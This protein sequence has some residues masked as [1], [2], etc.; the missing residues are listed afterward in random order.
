MVRI[1]RGDSDMLYNKKSRVV[2]ILL[3]IVIL[4]SFFTTIISAQSKN[5]SN[6]SEDNIESIALNLNNSFSEEERHPFVINRAASFETDSILVTISHDS[7]YDEFTVDYFS[8]YIQPDI[9]V[10]KIALVNP[11]QKEKESYH[12]I[13][14]FFI[15][16]SNENKAIR[17]AES[18]S[19]HPNI[20]CTSLN[21]YFEA[22]TENPNIPIDPNYTSDTKPFELI[23]AQDAWKTINEVNHVKVAVLDRGF[24]IHT[25]LEPNLNRDLEWDYEHNEKDTSDDNAIQHGTNVS[26]II[27][28]VWNL[29]GSAGMVRNIEIIPYQISTSATI[30]SALEDC[31]SNEIEILNMSV[32]LYAYQGAYYQPLEYALASFD[33]IIVCSAGNASVNT[34]LP[35]YCH[36]P[37]G[38]N[39]PC[40]LSIGSYD[41]EGEELGYFSNFGEQSVDIFAPGEG[42][43]MLFGSDDG[44]SYSTPFVTA[45]AAMLKSH[46]PEATNAEIIQAIKQGCEKPDWCE[47]LVQYGCLRVDN[48]ISVLQDILDSRRTLDDGTYVIGTS[49]NSFF[50]L[51]ISSASLS[52]LATCC[53]YES[54][55]TASQKFEIEYHEV[56]NLDN[57][58]TIKD[59][60]SNKYLEAASGGLVTGAYVQQNQWTGNAEQKWDIVYSG[61]N[62][63]HIINKANDL[64]IDYGLEQPINGHIATVETLDDT[65][66]QCFRIVPASDTIS[67]GTYQIL[68]Y[69]DQTK[70]YSVGKSLESGEYIS[71]VTADDDDTTQLFYI[72]ND[73]GSYRIISMYSGKSFDLTNNMLSL[74]QNEQSLVD[75]TQYYQI[76][77]TQLNGSDYTAKLSSFRTGKYLS[78][79]IGNIYLSNPV[80]GT[81]QKVILKRVILGLDS[82]I[83]ELGSADDYDKDIGT[84]GSSAVL[85]SISSNG[86]TTL[87]F[88]QD[89]DG[90]WSIEERTN[91][92]VLDVVNGTVCFSAA[93]SATASK[94]IINKLADDSLII[95]NYTTGKT[96]YNNSG[97]LSMGNY[98]DDEEYRFYAYIKGDI[99]ND[100]EIDMVDLLMQRRYVAGD[101]VL[102]DTELYC[103]DIDCD[104]DIDATDILM[105][106]QLIA[107][108][109]ELRSGQTPNMNSFRITMQDLLTMS[110]EEFLCVM[111]G[112]IDY[113]SFSIVIFK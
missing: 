12:A 53:T 101:I 74:D 7:S 51:D 72:D 112:N 65:D 38:Y 64:V 34:D 41:S 6:I 43:K 28:A 27:G 83:G 15:K 13:L 55:G 113:S 20:V 97:A 16:N 103:G 62:E 32:G 108:I 76:S 22:E 95:I 33:G 39:S 1:K 36:Y 94:W 56:P 21:Y 18:L 5:S 69:D 40:V 104:G 110:D 44:T 85:S 30:I 84:S 71:L 61:N 90:F 98:I 88:S 24:P 111:F 67:E 75:N 92:K 93:S 66:Y 42:I 35:Y 91:D 50:N 106:R 99:D 45:T 87:R 73:K 107:G 96:L 37:S 31:E 63:Y 3:L 80:S 8:N 86:R 58:Y 54:N 11:S 68:I 89:S 47:D 81:S 77:E 79:N 60:N 25:D 46:F 4:S 29:T 2:S 57:Y 100:N 78:K 102:N 48:S 70:A 49:G 17:L 105:L 109:I 9:E 26:G 14:Q 10:E 59:V 19:N 82:A 23:G 52:N